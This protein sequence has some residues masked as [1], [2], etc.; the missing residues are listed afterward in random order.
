MLG[1]K[2][3]SCSTRANSRTIKHKLAKVDT[4]V[5]PIHVVG[6]STN[7][8]YLLRTRSQPKDQQHYLFDHSITLCCTVTQCDSLCT[9]CVVRKQQ[10]T[11]YPDAVCALSLPN[12]VITC[13]QTS[14]LVTTGRCRD[15]PRN[16]PP[17]GPL[18]SVGNKLSEAHNG[19]PG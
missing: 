4:S 6:L 10:V 11:P 17:S 8:L 13:R 14:P 2:Q 1:A 18:S 3:R 15:A 7:I 19:A 16:E 5:A 9:Y 12:A